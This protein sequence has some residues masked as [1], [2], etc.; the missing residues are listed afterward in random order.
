MLN[1][2]GKHWW[3]FLLRGIV[4]ILFGIGTFVWPGMALVVLVAMFAAFTFV[5]GVA[6]V[7]ASIRH[8]TEVKHWWAYL[9]EG[10]L[11]VGVGVVTWFWPG[12]TAL[13]LLFMIAFWAIA[14]GIFEIIAAWK[15]REEITGEWALGLAGALSVAFGVVLVLRPGAGALAVVWLIGVY[16]VVFGILLTV[17][18]FKLR[19]SRGGAVER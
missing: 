8:R 9:L 5:D 7:I 13:A 1:D 12:I 10:L 11:G 16:A 15:L 19:G 2:F 3:V 4:A 18:A 6:A 14:T 17:V